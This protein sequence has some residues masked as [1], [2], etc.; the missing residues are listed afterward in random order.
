MSIKYNDV[1][2]DDA[3]DDDVVDISVDDAS[4]DDDVDDV[5]VISGENDAGVTSSSAD[6]ISDGW[7]G[8]V[9]TQTS[10]DNSDI[11][12]NRTV[13]FYCPLLVLLFKEIK[14]L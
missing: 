11:D 8:M 10:L 5:V 3:S 7:L 14:N 2:V 1:S 13:Q 4:D 12:P 6:S 9:T